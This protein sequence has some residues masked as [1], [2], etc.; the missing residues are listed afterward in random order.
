MNQKETEKIIVMTTLRP[1]AE[2]YVRNEQLT[3]IHDYLIQCNSKETLDF[4]S[5]RYSQSSSS[6]N[7]IPWNLWFKKIGV[8]TGLTFQHFA[9]KSKPNESGSQIRLRKTRK[10]VCL[11]YN[12]Q[13]P[14]L[15]HKTIITIDCDFEQVWSTLFITTFVLIMIEYP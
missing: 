13:T 8:R 7:T 4:I 2:V 9:K 12:L 15:D 1:A 3:I 10:V 11:P 6:N 5:D 14:V